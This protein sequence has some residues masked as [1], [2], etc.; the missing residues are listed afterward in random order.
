M[1]CE[2]EFYAEHHRRARKEH[3]CCETGRMIQPGEMYWICV[4]VWDGYFQQFKQSE[5]AYH[6]CRFI[7]GIPEKGT[8]RARTFDPDSCAPFGHIRDDLPDDYLPEWREVC[9]GKVTRNT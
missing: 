6:F 3:K 2:P 8:A 9:R 7:N 5:A 4:G 1:N